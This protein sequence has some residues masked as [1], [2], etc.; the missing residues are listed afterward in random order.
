MT[1]KTKPS[2]QNT[3]PNTRPNVKPDDRPDA[4]TET[5]PAPPAPPAAPPDAPSRVKTA[6][7]LTPYATMRARA[8][9][10]ISA[11][12][13]LA[14]GLVKDTANQE[15]NSE[16]V[17]ALA[18]IKID[19]SRANVTQ[20]ALHELH[21][22]QIELETQNEEL[23]LTQS[24]LEISRARYFHLY[25]MAPI[26]YCTIDK[27]GLILEANFTA[28]TLFGTQRGKLVGERFTRFI[29]SHSQDSFY[30]RRTQATETRQAQS[31]DI[32]MVQRGGAPFWANLT[33]T[34]IEQSQVLLDTEEMYIAISD[35]SSRKQAEQTVRDS[36]ANYRH[37]FNLID[38]GF[39]ILEM[40]FDAQKNPIDYRFVE[41]NPAF[42]LQTGLHQ[43]VGKRMSD[44]APGNESYW[45]EIYGKVALTGIP[46]RVVNEAKELNRWFDVYAFRIGNQTNGKV[47]VLFNDITQQRIRDV[48]KLELARLLEDKNAN[49]E[50]AMQ[51][52][53]KANKAKSDFLSSMSHELRTPLGAILGFAQLLDSGT[54]PP[55]PTQKR[56]IEQI[57]QAG[58]YLLELINEILDLALIESG[59]LSLSI[60][61]MSLSLVIQECQLMVESQAKHRN[62]SMTFP[63]VEADHQARADITRVKQV[64]INML[65][66]AI[67]YN[68]VGGSVV[69]RCI[70]NGQGRVRL[71]VEDTG[72]GLT[73]DQIANLFQPFNRLGQEASTEEGTGIGLVVCKRLV[74]LMGGT[75]GVDSIVGK[76]SVFWFELN[77][78]PAGAS[79]SAA[80]LG[81]VAQ[82]APPAAPETR[83]SA[84]GEALRPMRTVLYVEDN[85]ANLMLV[86]EI[87][88]RLPNIKLISAT[89]GKAGLMLARSTLPDVILMDINLPGI[90]GL[91]VLEHLRADPITAHIPVVA[92]SAN[93]MPYDIENGLGLGFFRYLTKPLKVPEFL[94]TL[95]LALTLHGSKLAVAAHYVKSEKAV[96]PIT[97]D[98]QDTPT[99]PTTPAPADPADP[100]D[101][102]ASIGQA[103]PNAPLGQPRPNAPMGQPVPTAQMGQCAAPKLLNGE[104]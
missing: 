89:D 83:E 34:E 18:S 80:L 71:C 55:S 88:T 86:E 60:E 44:V 56:S 13:P 66:N 54:P 47:A 37:L 23:R 104:K 32:Q 99:T 84:T 97:P 61:P 12:T 16:A 25:D 19:P 95:D 11:Q 4:P 27:N 49:L 67:K 41:T 48:E 52:A 40:I 74:E 33:F 96:K 92:L 102:T 9:K 31:M 35:I 78:A 68:K 93:A 58:W 87:V 15:G 94:A 91:V 7:P 53:D 24:A 42:E 79:G 46:I 3:R 76:G 39:S 10:T 36:E 90:S 57:L 8:E 30:V 5:P 100:P 98:A 51:I 26:G 1:D 75:I 14:S 82:Q 6:L 65:S 28:A 81:G 2:N 64:L 72:D 21:V 45:A 63:S 77:L 50:L 29:A 69:V 70:T 38:Q 43:V 20:R 101:A 103:L 22:H 17:S 85:P 62:I 73:A 59:K